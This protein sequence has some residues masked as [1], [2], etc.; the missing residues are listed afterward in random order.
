MMIGR[1]ELDRFLHSIGRDELD[2]RLRATREWLDKLHFQVEPLPDDLVDVA[3][4][5]FTVR[6]DGDLRSDKGL[7]AYV[8][9]FQTNY[10]EILKEM[11]AL[12]SE[13]IAHL[14]YDDFREIVDPVI[15]A[16]IDEWLDK[17][18]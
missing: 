10:L 16:A 1:R 15:Q 8:R 7:R 17:H 9:H 11:R 13:E 5:H 14:V 2:R 18:A 12:H 4:R 3:D 6:K